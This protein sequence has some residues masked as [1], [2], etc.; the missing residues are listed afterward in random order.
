MFQRDTR[1][2]VGADADAGGGLLQR[3]LAQPNIDG[4]RRGAGWV[5]IERDRDAVEQ[6]G[7]LQAF[8]E[9][10]QQRFSGGCAGFEVGQ[11]A[12][13]ALVLPLQAVDSQRAGAK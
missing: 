12:H 9:V 11:V 6:I 5:G 10:E 1:S 3:Q 4:G 8:L 7:L 2:G 13:A